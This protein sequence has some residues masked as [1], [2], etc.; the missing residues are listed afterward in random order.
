MSLAGSKGSSTFEQ[1]DAQGPVILAMLQRE[2]VAANAS[3]G[4][5]PQVRTSQP[6][7]YCADLEFSCLSTV[8]AH[9]LTGF[10]LVAVSTLLSR[11]Q[12]PPAQALAPGIAGIKT[13]QVIEYDSRLP[14]PDVKVYPF[15]L[16]C[17]IS[18]PSKARRISPWHASRR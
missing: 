12:G 5:A 11:A 9:G 3:G 1:L 2:W 17:P 7:S 4:V 10:R 15:R 14:V 18:S 8:H 6:C 13:Y 16:D